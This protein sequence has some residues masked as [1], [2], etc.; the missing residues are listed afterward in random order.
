MNIEEAIVGLSEALNIHSDILNKHS[1]TIK[2]LK[3]QINDLVIRIERL[4]RERR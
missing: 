3:N 2:L 1:E 4:E